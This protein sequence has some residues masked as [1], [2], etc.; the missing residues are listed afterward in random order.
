M[1][2]SNTKNYLKLQLFRKTILG[3]KTLNS[4]EYLELKIK[5]LKRNEKNPAKNILILET[6]PAKEE[7]QHG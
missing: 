5:T 7:L 3:L 4:L 6:Q 2:N 1:N